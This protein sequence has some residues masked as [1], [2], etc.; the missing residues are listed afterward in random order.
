[1][2]SLIAD[3]VLPEDLALERLAKGGRHKYPSARITQY[4]ADWIKELLAKNVHV[5]EIA[6]ELE[7]SVSLVRDIKNG[8]SWRH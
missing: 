1:M 5:K 8:E 3:K 6:E 4:E 2:P 7:I